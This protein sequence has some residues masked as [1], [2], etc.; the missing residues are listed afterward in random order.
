MDFAAFKRM[1]RKQHDKLLDA[2]MEEGAA[3]QVRSRP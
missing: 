3:A 2:V 1:D